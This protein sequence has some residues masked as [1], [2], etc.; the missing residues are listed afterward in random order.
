MIYKI[1]ESLELRLNLSYISI[2]GLYWMI[3]CCTISLGSAYLS[4]R[5]YSTVGIGALF[6]IAY[7]I[8]SILQQLISIE[9]DKS[10]RFDVLDV[11]AVLGAVLAIDLLF[12]VNT[13]VKG[14]GTGFTFLIAAMIATIMQPF[15]NALNFHIEKYDIKMNYGVARASGSFFF[16]IMSLLAGNLMKSIS[17]KAAPVLGLIVTILFIANVFWI[18]KELK[19]TGKEPAKDYDPFQ[20][21]NDSSFDILDSDSIKLFIEKYKMFFIFLIGLMGFYFGHVLINNFLYQITVNVGGDEADTGGLLAMQAIV[22]LPAMIFF[23]W[24]KDRFGSKLLLSFSAVFYFVKIFATT[25]ATSVG[26]LYFSMIFQALAF[27]VFIPAS[28]H[29]VDE[30]MS[31]KDAVKGQSFVTVAM[32]LSNLLSSLLGGILIR[33]VGVTASLWFGTIVTLCGVVVSI[34]GLVKIKQK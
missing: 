25:I 21:A 11:L 27:A 23:T 15:L 33:I 5:G 18:F 13:D 20:T 29:F 31:E 30:I 10:S 2:Q 22:E 28:V 24:L 6:A 1:K 12:A 32:T 34:Y 16:F 4:N 19:S 9:T 3:V 7:L 26:M 17:E 8:A 14:F